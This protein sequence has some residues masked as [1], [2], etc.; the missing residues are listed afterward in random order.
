MKKLVLFFISLTL[1]LNLFSQVNYQKLELV[2]IVDYAYWPSSVWGINSMNDGEHYTVFEYDRS[3]YSSLIN[4]YNY[5]TGEKIETIVNLTG[6]SV[7]LVSYQ[8]KFSNDEKKILI[9]ADKEEIYRYSFLANYYVYDIAKKEL[10][11][12]SENGMQQIADLSPDGQKVAF[13]RE[14]NIYIKDLTTKEEKQITTDGKKNSI[15]NGIPDWVYEEEFEF[16]QAY[17]WS[18][19]GKYLAYIKF[20]ESDVKE[21]TLLKYAGESPRNEDFSLYPGQYTFKY[22]K[23][24]E[25]NSKISLHIYNIENGNTSN[26]EVCKEQDIYFPRI[27]WNNDG[28][29]LIVEKLNREQNELILFAVNPQNNEVQK[30]LTEKNKYYI[31]DN[32]YDNIV[33]L[34][35][36]KNFIILSERDGFS[37]LYLYDLEGNLVNQITK[38]EY[39]VTDFIGYDVN[40]DIIYYQSTESSPLNRDIYSI[41]TD[42]KKKKKI[43][44]NDGTNEIEFSKGYKYYINT[45]SDIKTPNYVT[46]HNSKGNVLRVLEDNSDLKA[47]I[48]TFG[49]ENKSFF[50]FKTSE[51]V[52]LNGYRIVPPDFDSTKVYPAIL[53]QYSG[54]NSQSVLNSWE[55][56]WENYLAQQGFV[57]FC[58][59]PRGTGG[60]GEEFRKCTYKQLGKYETID[61]VEA[62]KYIGKLSYID[63]NKLGIWGWSYGGFMVLN[64]MT[65]GKGVFNTGVSVAPV[66]NWRYYDNIY[67]E[68]Y[69]GK[70]QDN[71]SGYDDN[72]PLNYAKDLQGNLFLAFGTADD[73]VHPQNSYEFIAKLIEAN[74]EFTTMPYIN[75]NHGIYGDTHNTSLHL[76][77][78]KTKFFIKH[79]INE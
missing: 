51:G 40:N 60:R 48:K 27:F 4:K 16:N 58:V 8:Y 31:D 2:K 13:I 57:I 24:G 34:E 33:F 14:N 50:K 75:R 3:T 9:Y 36:N 42:G 5:K 38:G 43:N 55:F 35:N 22:P 78:L 41:R 62:G 23:A 47:I 61:L 65:K 11:K 39:D 67:T 18:P 32:T 26:I 15:I 28:S 12:V 49:G 21:F 73:N 68:R 25:D 7:G 45:F 74:K 71:P 53:T 70:P 1:F 63:E 17:Q 76:Y 52:E 64:V 20:D 54:P 10:I 69:M 79:L 66:T 30:I 44:V 56:G 29:K 46:L 72:S 77:T 6:L 59:D 37:H 19:D